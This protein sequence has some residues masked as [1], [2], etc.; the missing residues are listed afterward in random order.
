MHLVDSTWDLFS[1]CV[2]GSELSSPLERKGLKEE[3]VALILDI[4]RTRRKAR[5][6]TS[7]AEELFFTSEGLRWATPEPAAVHCAERVKANHVMDISSGQGGQSI[8]LSETSDRV[9]A[10]D[11]SPLNCL[12]SYMNALSL[13]RELEIVNSDSLTENVRSMAQRDCLV[14]SDPARP[15][16]ARRRRLEEIEPDPRKVYATYSEKASGFCFE[17]PP[18]IDLHQ[19]PMDIEAEYISFQGRLNRLNVYTGELKRSERSAVILP[20][21]SVLRGEPRIVTYCEDAS[22][23][24]G[25]WISEIDHSVIRSGLAWKLAEG[26]DASVMKLDERRSVL[27]SPH[28][29]SSPFIGPAMEVQA[30]SE[31]LNEVKSILRSIDAGSVTIRFKVEPSDYWAI[32]NDLEQGLKGG[33]K[34]SLFKGKRYVV[35]VKEDFRDE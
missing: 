4:A 1:D 19:I 17:L 30:V 18:Y 27:V 29:I 28:P 33:K 12:I 15:P 13:N 22:I 25:S 32:R 8:Y 26:N 7:R 21:G 23:V 14:F 11:I 24:T 9:T 10:V 34:V 3:P 31:D 6:K 35:A 2:R 5:K 16:G 20:E